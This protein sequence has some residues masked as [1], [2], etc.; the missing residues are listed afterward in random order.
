VGVTEDVDLVP[1]PDDRNLDRLV[2]RLVR[3]DG[4]LTLGPGRTPGPEERRALYRGRNLSVSTPLG[5]LDVVQPLPGVP[6][7]SELATR[8]IVVTPSGLRLTVA[9]RADLIAMKRAGGRPI[10][11]ADLEYLEAKPEC[12]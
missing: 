9:S 12:D 8:A 2:N 6:A 10:D 11:V 5:D 3:E 4:R 7:Y 1:A